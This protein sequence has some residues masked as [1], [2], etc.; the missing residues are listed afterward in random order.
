[1]ESL[2]DALVILAMFL[3]RLGVPIVITVALGYFFHRLDQKWQQ[4]AEAQRRAVQP[5]P[6][7][8]MGQG[9]QMP[10]FVLAG[11]P[12]WEV[13]G[14]DEAKRENCPAGKLPTTTPCW[15]TRTQVV[16]RLPAAC[17]QCEL[18]NMARVDYNTSH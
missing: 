7:S 14:C 6:R 3:V 15:L 5:Q 13:K 10:S 9:Q 17:P 11:A 12:C 1:M 16:G 8:G 18:Y 2:T 4:E